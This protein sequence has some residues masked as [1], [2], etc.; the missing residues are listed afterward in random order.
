MLH[1]SLPGTLVLAWAWSSKGGV[2]HILTV[3]TATVEPRIILASGTG[4]PVRCVQATCP[5][6]P[7]LT[8]GLLRLLPAGKSCC[9]GEEEEGGCKGTLQPR[10]EFLAELRSSTGGEHILFFVGLLGLSQ[11]GFFFFFS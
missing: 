11:G 4:R 3:L 9:R 6:S 5:S 2:Q 7:E 1:A 8:L 10:A